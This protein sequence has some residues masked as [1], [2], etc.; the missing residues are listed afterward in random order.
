MSGDPR[1]QLSRAIPA[2]ILER[3]YTQA[4]A[5]FPNECCGYLRGDGMDTRFVPCTNIMDE[6]HAR[7][8]AR[9]S[10]RASNGYQFSV[11][12]FM[13]FDRSFSADPP[14]T[15]IYHSH[16]RVGAYFSNE[17]TRAALA[18]HELG[19]TVDY[20]VVDAQED[21]IRGA[22]LFRRDGARFLE[23]ARFPGSTR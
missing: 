2:K 21:E 9:Y 22:I 20:L 5:E 14:A 7:D 19:Y 1:A 18:F 11:S 23:I 16:P 8:P 3:I 17:D 10:R 4:R 12:D 6:L 15:V 13:A